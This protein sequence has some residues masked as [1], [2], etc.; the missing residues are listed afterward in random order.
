MWF[1]V[2]MSGVQFIGPLPQ[3]SCQMAAADLRAAGVVCREVSAMKACPVPGYPEGSTFTACPV[4]DF[5]KV[6][7]KP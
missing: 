4:F 1:L 3:A 7:V 6:T 5:P 2:F